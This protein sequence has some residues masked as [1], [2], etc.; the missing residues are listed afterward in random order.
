[1]L[2]KQQRPS[3]EET[4]AHGGARRAREHDIHDVVRASN[5]RAVNKQHPAIWQHSYRFRNS[6]EVPVVKNREALPGGQSSE[7][8]LE[9]ADVLRAGVGLELEQHALHRHLAHA[10]VVATTQPNERG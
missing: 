10:A 4:E 1:M 7:V 6:R 8:E 3:P 2:S 5:R 9:V